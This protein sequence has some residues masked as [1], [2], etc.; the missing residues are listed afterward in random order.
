MSSVLSTLTSK[1]CKLSYDSRRKLKTELQLSLLG[2]LGRRCLVTLDA[3]LSARSL[4]Q[5]CND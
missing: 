3:H 4:L 2:N 1:I 5:S